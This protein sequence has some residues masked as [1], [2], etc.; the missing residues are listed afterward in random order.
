MG[1][2]YSVKLVQAAWLSVWRLTIDVVVF[3]HSIR[4]FVDVIAA[5]IGVITLDAA[6][7]FTVAVVA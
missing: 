3:G 7:P 6:Y 1:Y 4:S 5:I 2:Q